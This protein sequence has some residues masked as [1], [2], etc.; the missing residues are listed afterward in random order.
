MEIDEWKEVAVTNDITGEVE[1]EDICTGDVTME[2][3][4]EEKYLGDL[5]STDGRNLK[6]IKARISKGKGIVKKIL[7]VLDGIPFGRHYFEIGMLLRDS[8]LVS[9]VLFNSEAW[10]HLTSAELDLLETIDVSFLR[11]LLQAPMGTPKEM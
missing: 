4:S 6:N 9:S 8:L 11:Q 3:T 2:E 7:T 1:I 10:Y 5:I